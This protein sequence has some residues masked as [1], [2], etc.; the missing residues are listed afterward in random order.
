MTDN[1]QVV[2]K[3]YLK[4]LAARSPAPGGGSAQA[5]CG[6][7]GM[8]LLG[9]SARYSVDSKKC[10]ADRDRLADIIRITD[11]LREKLMVLETRDRDAYSNYRHA[12]AMPKKP[13]EAATTRLSTMQEALKTCAEIP[14][15]A[16]GLCLEGMDLAMELS[17]IGSPYLASDVGCAAGFFAASIK[18]GR[19]NVEVNTANIRDEDFVSEK[20]KS[21]Y[22][23]LGRAERDVDAVSRQ[24]LYRMK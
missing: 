11:S 13:E 3:D 8:A 10:T 17:Q 14:M 18:A 5:L 7:M 16:V 6:A 24:C 2:I 19:L 21:I 15:E 1:K 20:K 9:M 22:Q 23:A 4:A 12:A